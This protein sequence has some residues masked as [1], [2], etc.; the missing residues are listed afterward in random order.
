VDAR[1][2]RLAER[3]EAVDLVAR[4][5]FEE[6]GSYPAE[7]GLP[8]ARERLAAWATPDGI[9]SAF[10]ALSDGEPAGSACLVDHDMPDPPE[11]TADL[12]PWLSGVFVRP[13]RRKTG[14]GPALVEAVEEAAAALGHDVLYLYTGPVTAVKFYSPMGWEEILRPTYRGE[15]VVVMRKGLAG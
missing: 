2:V 13:E 9:P 7:V 5:H 10:L 6:W 8:A 12:A 3:P 15:E 11:G 14:L 1:V 4:W